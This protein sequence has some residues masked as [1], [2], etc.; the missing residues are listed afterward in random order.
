MDTVAMCLLEGITT[1]KGRN[2]LA[3]HGSITLDEIK[4]VCKLQNTL[5]PTTLRQ[6]QPKTKAQMLF[7]FIY[8]RLGPL[9]IQKINTR[10][11]EIQQNGPTLLKLS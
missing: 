1:I 11:E 3:D 7:Y 9:P 10:L 8:G 6:V 5:V 2:L 4:E